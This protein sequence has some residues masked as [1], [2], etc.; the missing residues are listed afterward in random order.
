MKTYLKADATKDKDGKA[1]TANPDKE[2]GSC[3]V[4]TNCTKI[5]DSIFNDYPMGLICVD[6][7]KSPT[8]HLFGSNSF[9]KEESFDTLI[10]CSTCLGLDK[11]SESVT[12]EATV[13]SLAKEVYEIKDEVYKLE[14][15]LDGTLTVDQP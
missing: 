13:K 12:I 7:K 4:E 6:N 1:I 15:N 8:R 11:V 5:A 9:D 10:R 2:K 3:M 14:K